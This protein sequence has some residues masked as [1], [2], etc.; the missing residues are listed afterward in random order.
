M[1]IAVDFD[2]TCVEH[3]YP[4]IGPPV[5]GAVQTLLDLV[6]SGH[7]LVIWTMR[8]H[9]H[10][11][12]AEEWFVSHGISFIGANRNPGQSWSSSPKVYAHVYIDDAALGCPLR[13]GIAGD[14]PM[15]DWEAVAVLLKESGL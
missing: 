3:L 4:K 7:H 1:I 10:L 15:V 9:A 6:A 8:D 5:P 14:R 13:P 12:A 2:G 11:T